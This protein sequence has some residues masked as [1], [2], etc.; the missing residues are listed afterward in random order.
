MRLTVYTDYALRV[1]MYLAVHPEPTPTIGEIARSHGVSRNHLMKVVYELG[2]AGYIETTRGRGGGLRLAR[3]P[4]RIG[5]GEVVRQTEPDLALVPC[6]E[7]TRASCVLTPA[8]KLR[9]ALRRAEA[10]FLDVLDLYSLA[11]LVEN[12]E[13]LRALLDRSAGAAAISGNS[14]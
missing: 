12:H 2:V 1:L 10:A 9:A 11:N 13:A 8:C 3:P 6:F 7:P 4:E 14:A 5:L